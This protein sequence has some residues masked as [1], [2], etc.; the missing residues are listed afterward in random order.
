MPSTVEA[1]AAE[2]WQVAEAA[3]GESEAQLL[4]GA[5]SKDNI[6]VEPPPRELLTISCKPA[7]LT[8]KVL[9]AEGR[10][11]KRNL[12]V[13]EVKVVEEGGEAWNQGVRP[14]QVCRI[15]EWHYKLNTILQHQ[16]RL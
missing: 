9:F 4:T 10:T 1:A 6:K 16:Q 5:A 15:I 12:R 8:G 11:V 7:D 2:G 13:V 14:G 3:A